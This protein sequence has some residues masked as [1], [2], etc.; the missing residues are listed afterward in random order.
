MTN[1]KTAK[2]TGSGKEYK[3]HWQQPWVQRVLRR[4]YSP[5]EKLL[6][7]RIASFGAKGCTMYNRTLALELG[8]SERYVKRGV[9]KLWM[10]KE[11]WITGWDSRNRCIYAHHN[12]EVAAMAEAMFKAERKDGKVTDKDDFYRQH[13][14]RGYATV[15]NSTRINEINREREYTVKPPT[16]NDSTRMGEQ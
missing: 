14:M 15:N 16:V 8:C 1:E 2:K 10:G 9:T 12:P 5:F 6:F 7:M 3:A 4:P 13:K 11:F